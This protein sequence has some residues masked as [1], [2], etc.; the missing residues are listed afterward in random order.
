MRLRWKYY[1]F[2]SVTSTCLL[3]FETHCCSCP[4]ALGIPSHKKSWSGD[5]ASTTNLRPVWKFLEKTSFYWSVMLDFIKLHSTY[6]DQDTLSM[7]DVL[8]SESVL[9]SSRLVR[10]AR[11]SDKSFGTELQEIRW[12]ERICVHISKKSIWVF[13]KIWTALLFL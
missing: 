1:R 4:V 6:Y 7:A 13:T 12:S 8:V 9:S 3:F 2:C 10:I 5:S 11:H